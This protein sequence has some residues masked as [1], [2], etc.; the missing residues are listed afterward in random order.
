MKNLLV[1]DGIRGSLACSGKTYLCKPRGSPVLWTD[2]F[3]G[4]FQ[5]IP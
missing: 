2:G 4:I 5:T 1:K 3:T